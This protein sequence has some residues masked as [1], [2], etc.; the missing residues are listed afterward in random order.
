MATV[1]TGIYGQIQPVQIQQQNPLAALAQVAQLNAYQR[2]AEKDA[3]LSE[4]QNKLYGLVQ[5]PEFGGM[6][7][8]GKAA[9]L[10]GVGA[11]DEAGKVITSDA[12]ANKDAREA[13]AKEFETAAKRFEV[14]GGAMGRLSQNP[15]EAPMLLQQL[16]QAQVIPT[17]YAQKIMQGAS[18]APDPAQFFAAGAQAA[19]KSKD[20]VDQHLE[21]L[22][23]GEAQRHNRAS[24]GLQGQGQQIT[25]RGQDL[26][27][28]TALRGQ[29]LSD[30]RA[31]EFNA[32]KTEEN[33]LKREERQQTTDM[34]KASQIAS[35]DT[36]L[37]TLDRLG[38]HKGLARSVGVESKFPTWPGSDSANFQAE[39]EAFK[40]QAF[41][42]MV[43]QLKGM[44]AL[45]DAEGRKLTAA[46]GALEP[47]MGDKAFKESI[48][49]IQADMQAARARVASTTRG[50]ATSAESGAAPAAP[51]AGGMAAPRSKAE[52][53]ALPPGTLFRAPDG[54]TRRKP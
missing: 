24:E 18:Q 14:V 42:P 6:D 4:R 30:A 28:E 43:A 20:Q 13:A 21:K 45:S 37:G 12:A 16:V 8:R 22:R 54:T 3:L 53:D 27:R 34:T 47:S 17:E 26:G 51:P 25:M 44:G 1:D 52:M 9:A 41:V 23:F 29:D 35:F 40:S 46:V 7:A 11:F 38:T 19:I 2:S 5:S 49:R 50:A 36:M 10:Q 31:R 39:L 15:Q 48:Q 32:T 33:Q